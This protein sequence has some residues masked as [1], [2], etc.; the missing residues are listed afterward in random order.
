MTTTDV[1]HPTL[2]AAPDAV[3]V[4]SVTRREITQASGEV[5]L[6]DWVRGWVSQVLPGDDQAATDAAQVALVAYEGG[7]SLSE[8]YRE[9]RRFVGSWCRHPSHWSTG[10]P[11][12]RLVS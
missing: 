12:L 2:L 6:L 1:A 10:K 11:S 8:A 3:R 9:A 4:P 5:V 7:A